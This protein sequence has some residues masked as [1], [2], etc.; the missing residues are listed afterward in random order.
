[1]RYLVLNAD[2]MQS[3]GVLET[4]LARGEWRSSDWKQDLLHAFMEYSTQDWFGT[5]ILMSDRASFYVIDAIEGDG[6][7]TYE[8][9]HGY[10]SLSL[11][12]SDKIFRV[13]YR[14][15]NGNSRPMSALTI[16]KPTAQ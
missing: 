10:G 9:Y 14:E 8:L 15:E 4:Y 16:K 6:D 13:S 7:A 3:E 1:M 12:P 11:D 5:F 2:N